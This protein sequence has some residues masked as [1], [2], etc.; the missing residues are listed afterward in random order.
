M[1][2]YEEL[3]KMYDRDGHAIFVM[4][5]S[6]L[7]QLA[8]KT[9]VND[10][11]TSLIPGNLFSEETKRAAID[12]AK[13][14]ASADI[15]V[16][17]AVIQRCV[18]PINDPRGEKVPHLH[19]YGD[20]EGICP[21]CQGQLEYLGDQEIVDDGTLVSWVCL[22]CG[23]TGEEGSDIV[24]DHHYSVCDADGKPVKGR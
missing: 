20:M 17:L 15:D 19:E 9:L 16:L 18:A 10:S 14:I 4:A 24:F 2:D 5:I 3:K 6:V 11:N 8:D 21:L 22:N 12:A 23:A 13:Q 7:L 1:A